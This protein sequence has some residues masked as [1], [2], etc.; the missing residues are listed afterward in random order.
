[1]INK[2]IARR[3]AQAIFEIAREQNAVEKFAQDL[4]T[5][6]DSIEKNPDI[7]KFI[8]GRLIPAEA[9]KEIIAKMITPE[10]NQM[11]VNFIYLIMD[12]SRENYL[13]GIVDAFDQLAAEEKKIV[14]AQVLSAIPLTK[15]QLAKLEAKLSEKTGRSV[16]A[17]IT[18][19]PSLIGGL[20]VRIGDIV[21]DGSI[22][23]QLGMLKEHLQQDTVGKIGVR[24]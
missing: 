20:A 16:K 21:Y 4:K 7:K 19:D 22:V 3:Y 18:V 23:K 9:K 24:Q 6:V 8:Y 13:T 1:M 10:M 5:I 14:P 11:V 17:Q 12:K 2:S 15:D